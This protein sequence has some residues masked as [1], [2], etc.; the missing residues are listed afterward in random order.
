MSYDLRVQIHKLQAQVQELRVQI[1]E[2]QVQTQ[3]LEH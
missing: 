2:L 3:K 1:H